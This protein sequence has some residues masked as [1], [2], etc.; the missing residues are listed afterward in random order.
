[1]PARICIAGGGPTGL[2]MARLLAADGHD[3]TIYEA[4]AEIG[5]LCRSRDVEGYTFDLAGGHIMFTR[6]ERVSAF[7][8]ELFE[9]EPCVVT[10]RRTRI[11]HARDQ[12]VSYPFENALG[13]LPLEH[14]LECTE[15]VIRAHLARQAGAPE[16]T[17]FQAW[18]DWKM[19][20]GVAKHFMAP[21]NRKIWKSDLSDMSTGWIAGRVPDAPIADVLRSSLGATTE[22]YTHQSVFRYPLNGGFADVHERIARPIRDRIQTGHRVQHIEQRPGGGWR[23]DDEDFDQVISTIPLHVLPDVMP[24]LEPTAA[25]AARNLRYRG[26]A[27]Y[28]LGIEEEFVQPYS[29]VYLP[30]ENLGPANRITYLSNYSPN[31]APTGKGSIMAEVTYSGAPPATDKAGRQL[32]AEGLEQAGLLDAGRLTVTDAAINPVSYILYDLDF[33]SKR[34]T[35][36]ASLDA[37][38]GFHA[39]GRFGRYEYHNSDQCLAQ[40]MDLHARMESALVRGGG[41]DA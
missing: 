18:I 7:W 34:S 26:V 12:W 38:P 9:D 28:L 22:G 13:E 29:W 23:V 10:Q 15:G 6:D 36:L 32:V 11:L 3:V 40:A 31:N 21:Y 33:D 41:P 27:A 35:L 2:M 30:H 37:L 14:N 39:V 4:D 1:M 5:G 24:G 17:D 16:P 25:T 8:D 19:G 20:T